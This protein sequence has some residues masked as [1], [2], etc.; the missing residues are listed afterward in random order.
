MVARGEGRPYPYPQLFIELL[1]LLP[2]E[3]L[4]RLVAGFRP[5][6]VGVGEVLCEEDVHAN[7]GAVHALTWLRRAVE[8]E[9]KVYGGGGRET[10][11]LSLEAAELEELVLGGDFVLPG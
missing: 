1:L 5:G 10:G 6:D 8:L 2:P 4:L 3:D 7:S 9:G 11:L